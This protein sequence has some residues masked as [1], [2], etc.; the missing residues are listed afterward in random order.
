[1]LIKNDNCELHGAVDS[2]IVIL[3]QMACCIHVF[4]AVKSV[5]FGGTIWIP[6]C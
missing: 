2:S 4:K 3:Q 6:F 5:I 1:M